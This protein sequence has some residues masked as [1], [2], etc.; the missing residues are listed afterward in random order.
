MYACMYTSLTSLRLQLLPFTSFYIQI[1][2]FIQF[3]SIFNLNL[4]TTTSIIN[5]KFI[6]YEC[7]QRV[8]IAR[9]SIYQITHTHTHSCACFLS[10]TSGFFLFSY[11]ILSFLFSHL[12]YLFFSFILPLLFLLPKSFLLYFANF[13]FFLS[14][15]YTSSTHV[16]KFLLHLHIT[17]KQ[18]YSSFPHTHSPLFHS[19]N[20]NLAT[21]LHLPSLQP[22][23]KAPGQSAENSTLTVTT[24][25]RQE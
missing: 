15:S 9:T 7:V 19:Q 2:H 14:T 21:L 8:I 5:F 10:V 12:L 4:H 25:L 13:L 16:P 1:L 24:Q 20:L 11:N 18:F 17:Y 23:F 22:F 3:I 6:F